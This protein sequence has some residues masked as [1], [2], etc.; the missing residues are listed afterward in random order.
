MSRALTSVV[1]GP[2]SGPLPP[3][4]QYAVGLLTSQQPRRD[5]EDCSPGYHS[6]IGVPPG[7]RRRLKRGVFT[8]RQFLYVQTFMATFLFPE[9]RDDP[10]PWAAGSRSPP[11]TGLPGLL[12]VCVWCRSRAGRTPTGETVNRA[13]GWACGN[14]RWG[15]RVEWAL[16]RHTEVVGKRGWGISCPFRGEDPGPWSSCQG[17]GWAGTQRVRCFIPCSGESSGIRPGTWGCF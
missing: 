15:A 10:Y 9:H 17:H 16:P 11:D 3:S 1:G 4:L 8:L 2:L 5:S 12:A 6:F 7:R 13:Q 14:R